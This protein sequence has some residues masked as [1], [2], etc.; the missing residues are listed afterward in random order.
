MGRWA[1]ARHRGG[2]GLPTVATPVL[3]SVGNGNLTWT[4]PGDPP[5][6]ALVYFS[7]DG[8]LPFVLDGFPSWTDGDGGNEYVPFNGAGLYYV[9]GSTDRINPSTPVSNTVEVI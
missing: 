6:W 8:I 5:S 3:V 1:Q 2:G 4:I 7:P 9:Y